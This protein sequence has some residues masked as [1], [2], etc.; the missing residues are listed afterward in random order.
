MD[1][2]ESVLRKFFCREAPS[3]VPDPL[4]QGAYDYPRDMV[5]KHTNHNSIRSFGYKT[6]GERMRHIGEVFPGSMGSIRGVLRNDKYTEP[7]T[8]LGAVDSLLRDML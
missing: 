6:G 5:Y 4:P 7:T 2:I 3:S 8:R 1:I